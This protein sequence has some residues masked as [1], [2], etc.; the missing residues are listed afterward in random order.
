MRKENSALVL[1]VFVLLV[2]MILG[3][4]FAD[5]DEETS[6]Y[7]D[8]LR[9]YEKVLIEPDYTT[10]YENDSINFDIGFNEFSLNEKPFLL[11]LI[12]MFLNLIYQIL[13]GLMDILIKNMR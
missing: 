9:D 7:E 8:F 13:R 2:S 3:I 6:E 1:F 4:V 5:N 10:V 11:N 12:K